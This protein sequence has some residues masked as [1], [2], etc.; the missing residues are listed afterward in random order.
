[1]IVDKGFY[2]K[3]FAFP[4]GHGGDDG[5]AAAA[6]YLTLLKWKHF[7]KASLAFAAKMIQ[8]LM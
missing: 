5:G 8:K 1:L 4:C 2:D 7:Q 6:L 3:A